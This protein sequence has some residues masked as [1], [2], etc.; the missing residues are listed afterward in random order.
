MHNTLV[1][2]KSRFQQHNFISNII[3]LY[4]LNTTSQTIAG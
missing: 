2:P 4:E 3:T 1:I